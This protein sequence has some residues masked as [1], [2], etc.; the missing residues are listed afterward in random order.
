MKKDFG[1]KLQR[2]GVCESLSLHEPDNEWTRAIW[3]EM[4]Y[5]FFSKNIDIFGFLDN[6]KSVKRGLG[7]GFCL[8]LATPMLNTNNSLNELHGQL[9]HYKKSIKRVCIRYAFF[10][11][12]FFENR[13][14]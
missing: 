4:G 12:L 6:E 9:V 7:E 2:G 10:Q 11:T 13:K 8:S 3:A 14:R 5:P 1:R